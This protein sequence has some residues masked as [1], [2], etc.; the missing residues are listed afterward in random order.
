MIRQDLHIGTARKSCTAS[1]EQCARPALFFVLVGKLSPSV[2]LIHL[3]DAH[4]DEYCCF[5]LDQIDQPIA[6]NMDR[7]GQ[8]NPSGPQGKIGGCQEQPPPCPDHRVYRH[9]DRY[10]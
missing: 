4:C 2:A 5:W 8:Q 10:Y 7:G 9:G 3:S 6:A 1:S